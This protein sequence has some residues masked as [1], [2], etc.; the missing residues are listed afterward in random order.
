M[1]MLVGSLVTVVAPEARAF[2][3]TMTCDPQ[4]PEQN[5]RIDSH[6][7]VVDGDPLFWPGGAVSVWVNSAGSALRGIS[8]DATEVELRRGYAPWMVPLCQNGKPPDLDVTV[9][10]QRSGLVAEYD[11]GGGENLNA[12]LYQDLEW[13]YDPSAVAITTMTFDLN[14]GEIVDADTELNARDYPFAT[15]PGPDE[16]DLR[17]VLTHENGHVIGL[18]H[19]DVSNATMQPEARGFGFTELRSLAPDDERGICAIYE[20]QED[21]S[22]CGCVLARRSSASARFSGLAA[23]ILW[24]GLRRRVRAVH[25]YHPG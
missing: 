24:V 23:F 10:G 16:V 13:P 9:D 8:G 20:E 4:N 11:D 6:G 12:V 17:A 25:R 14:S 15:E 19:S 21:S 22:G 1:G 5:C 3:R 18:A 2:C 7:C